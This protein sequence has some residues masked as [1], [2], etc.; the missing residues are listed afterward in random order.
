MY[1]CLAMSPSD[2]MYTVAPLS[3]VMIIQ[4]VAILLFVKLKMMNQ[5]IRRKLRKA[6]D[7]NGRYQVEETLR[8]L[9]TLSPFFYSSYA[10]IFTYLTLMCLTMA[11]SSSLN[12]PLFL[13]LIEGETRYQ[14][15]ATILH[16]SPIAVMVQRKE[17]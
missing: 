5:E 8:S 10:F 12:T 4:T 9:S 6:G 3:V 15:D 17:Y 14:L 1:Y 13:A 11:L 2:S 7:Y 16:V